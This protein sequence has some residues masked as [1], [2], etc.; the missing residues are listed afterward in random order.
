MKVGFD[1]VLAIEHSGG[2]YGGTEDS[3][4]A[5]GGLVAGLR[6]LHLYAV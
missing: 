3:D 1:G 2:V 5:R 4:L 6:D